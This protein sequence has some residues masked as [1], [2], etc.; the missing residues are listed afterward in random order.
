MKKPVLFLLMAAVFAVA[1][2]GALFG[3]TNESGTETPMQIP[4]GDI[5]VTRSQLWMFAIASVTPLI[6]HGIKTVVPRIPKPML[7]ISTPIV[8][9]LLGLLVNWL[10]G[11]QLAWLDMTSAGA[12][13]VFVRE[14]WNQNVTRALVRAH[15]IPTAP[16]PPPAPPAAPAPA[17]EPAS[18]AKPGG[19]GI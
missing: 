9:V 17:P 8:G 16:P 6:I 2:T 15:E 18:E 19:D 4:I 11:K 5:P 3:Q 1:F 12:M 13:A 7:P 14:A 10:A